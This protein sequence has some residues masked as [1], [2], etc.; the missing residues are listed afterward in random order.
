MIDIM[1]DFPAELARLPGHV[2]HASAGSLLFCRGERVRRM[3]LVQRGC[4][5]LRRLDPDG[6]GAVMQR[7]EAGFLLAESSLFADRY[8]C[9]AHVIVDSQLR[10]IN[11]AA[12][13]RA[14]EESPGLVR[15]LARHLAHEVQRTRIRVEVLGKKTVKEK[16]DTW[17]VLHAG[18]LPQKGGWRAVA[19]DLNVSP[20]ALYRE[21]KRRELKG[22]GSIS[23]EFK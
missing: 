21:L 12:V 8:H 16:L 10:V 11:K 18:A 2:M 17:L 9:D 1:S 5:H 7:A 15:D 3:Y 20:E 22:V 4:V 14:L 19:E 13:E 23:G 6:A